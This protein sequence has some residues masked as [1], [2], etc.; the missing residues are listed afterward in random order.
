MQLNGAALV[1]LPPLLYLGVTRAGA[2]GAA[3]AWALV[4][5]ATLATGMVAMHRRYLHGEALA[6]LLRDTLPPAALAATVML[7]ARWL[8]PQD[9]HGWAVAG[10]LGAALAAAMALCA[11]A[12]P[13]TRGQLARWLPGARPNPTG[14][15]A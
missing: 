13:A 4:A 6:W 11:I 2:T 7:A 10:I 14:P 3:T 9:A 1:L 15:Q 5:A 12:A 8:L